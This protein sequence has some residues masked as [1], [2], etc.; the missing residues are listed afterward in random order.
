MYMYNMGMQ[1]GEGKSRPDSTTSLLSLHVS[2]PSFIINQEGINKHCEYM[3]DVFCRHSQ[4]EV[5]EHWTTYRRYRDFQDM[6]LTLRNQ[7]SCMFCTE[8]SIAY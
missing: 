7:V 4:A 8:Y 6:D 1:L 2:V 3:L 5:E